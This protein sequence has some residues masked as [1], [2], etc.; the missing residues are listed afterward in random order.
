[1]TTAEFRK[2]ALQLPEAVE[3]AHMNHPDFRVGGKIFASLGP[4]RSGW[5]MVK[6]TPQQQQSFIRSSP[7]AFEPCQGAWGRGGAT[8]V[9]LAAAGKAVVRDALTAAWLNVAPRRLIDAETRS[10]PQ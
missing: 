6:L 1:M 2:L 5:G 7:K 10:E 4:P 8:Y 9:C 3:A